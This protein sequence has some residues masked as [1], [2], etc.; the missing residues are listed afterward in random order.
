M[1]IYPC[2]FFIKQIIATLP[3]LYLYILKIVKFG[4]KKIELKFPYA[5]HNLWTIK[6]FASNIK[7]VLKNTKNLNEDFI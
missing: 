2:D 6:F 1:E 7:I 3:R 4:L 5:G